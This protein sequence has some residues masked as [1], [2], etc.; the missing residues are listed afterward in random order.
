[1]FDWLIRPLIR[2]EIKDMLDKILSPI[3]NF[4][5]EIGLKTG[6]LVAIGG[7]GAIF[8]LEWYGKL[9]MYS[10]ISIGAITAIFIVF[11]ALQ[12]KSLNGE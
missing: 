7:I 4:L 11:R 9:T 2:K 8:A 3:L 5:K 12:R 10:A 6:G 1:M